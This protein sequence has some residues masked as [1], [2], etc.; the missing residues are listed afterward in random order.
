MSA[1]L[2]M[3]PVPRVSPPEVVISPP[4]VA[5]SSEVAISIEVDEVAVASGVAMDNEHRAIACPLPA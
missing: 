3:R 1:V 5:I 4:E 2:V